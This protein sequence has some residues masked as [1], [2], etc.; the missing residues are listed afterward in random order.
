MDRVKKYYDDS[1]R[2]LERKK[3]RCRLD[4]QETRSIRDSLP[5]EANSLL[6]VGC[7]SG[8]LLTE[9]ESGFKLGIDLSEGML[10]V[11]RER[12]CRCPLV[13]A[14]ARRLPIKSSEFEVVVCQDVMGHFSEVEEPLLE[15]ARVCKSNGLMAITVPKKGIISR[16]TSLYCR[17]YLGVYTR[18]F[19]REELEKI[20]ENAGVHIISTEVI[21]GSMFKVI[22]T[23]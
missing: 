19:G 8:H 23:P 21:G 20:F 22:A 11:A 15:L 5:K 7:G 3:T 16:L 10:K 4:E 18:T 12:G 9:A 1:A 17:F 2:S 13:L 14:N 6:D